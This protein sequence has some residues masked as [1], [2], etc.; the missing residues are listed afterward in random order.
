[1]PRRVW[2]IEG[3]DEERLVFE[4]PI[5]AGSLTDQE[6][7]ALLQRLASRYLDEDQIVDSSLNKVTTGYAPYLEVVGS[8]GRFG[9]SGNKFTYTATVRDMVM[10]FS[11]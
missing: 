1:M 9:I 5:P 8:A 2:M 11:R 4:R 6:V 10:E 7:I 3:Y